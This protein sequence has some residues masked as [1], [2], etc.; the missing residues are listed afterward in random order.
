MSET[1]CGCERCQPARLWCVQVLKYQHSATRSRK[2]FVSFAS[3]G[4]DDR[5]FASPGSDDCIR[6]DTS[7]TAPAAPAP[8]E[9]GTREEPAVHEEDDFPMPLEEEEP[10]A[11]HE[12]EPARMQQSPA[13]MPPQHGNRWP[14]PQHLLH[15]LRRQDARA[16]HS[17]DQVS[18]EQFSAV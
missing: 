6:A 12:Q 3:P 1:R 18:L 13:R 5:T 14:S 4:G 15:V 10:F 7:A 2:K 11:Q 8:K 16:A 9:G 17:L